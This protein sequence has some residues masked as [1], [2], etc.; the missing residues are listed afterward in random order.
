MNQ[1]ET[2]MLGNGEAHELANEM[3]SD[4]NIPTRK[5]VTHEPYIS[6]IAERIF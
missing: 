2:P 4:L 5:Q 3:R 6:P 1:N